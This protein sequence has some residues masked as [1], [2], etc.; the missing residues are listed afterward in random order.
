MSQSKLLKA[1]ILK[2]LAKDVSKGGSMTRAPYPN[3]KAPLT[4][5]GGKDEVGMQPFYPLAQEPDPAAT[6]MTPIVPGTLSKKDPSKRATYINSKEPLTFFGGAKKCKQAKKQAKE[7]CAEEKKDKKEKKKRAPSAYNLFIKDFFITNKPTTLAAAAAAWKSS[8][9]TAPQPA[10]EA[11]RKVE[12][13]PEAKPKKKRAKIALTTFQP[14]PPPP[15]PP[16]AKKKRGGRKPNAGKPLPKKQLQ[17]YEK[18]P[19]PKPRTKRTSAWMAHLAEFRK[20]N[21]SVKPRDVMKEAKKTYKKSGGAH[22]GGELILPVGGAVEIKPDL[23]MTDTHTMRDGTTMSGKSHTV[24][25]KK[26]KEIM[27]EKQA[28]NVPNAP[29]KLPEQSVADQKQIMVDI[30]NSYDEFNKRFQDIS[31]SNASLG[32]KK[33]Q[34]N[35]E[36]DRADKYH[37]TAVKNYAEVLSADN[38]TIEEKAYRYVLETYKIGMDSLKEGQPT[39]RVEFE[40]M[41]DQETITKLID[42][43]LAVPRTALDRAKSFFS[44]PLP[45]AEIQKFNPVIPALG[46]MATIYPYGR[47]MA[48]KAAMGGKM[49]KSPKQM[50]AKLTRDMFIRDMSRKFPKVSRKKI[51]EVF[52]KNKSD[53]KSLI[54][55]VIID[56]IEIRGGAACK[57]GE[58]ASGDRCFKKKERPEDFDRSKFFAE[59][60]KEADSKERKD[61]GFVKE[62]AAPDMKKDSGTKSSSDAANPMPAPKPQQKDERNFVEKFSAAVTP[63]EVGPI[64]GTDSSDIT[65]ARDW[66]DS[67]A[68]IFLGTAKGV[69]TIFDALGDLF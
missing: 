20:N 18:K 19:E 6:P 32:N 53:I 52:E 11:P 65:D 43:A 45:K 30:M 9:S 55:D 66:V 44:V 24:D 4:F 17:S 39:Q 60:K 67:L 42:Q 15:G 47:Q 33:S 54:T 62:N 38:K 21:K 7:V 48:E 37:A 29:E 51:I 3:A 25:S 49:K 34:Y 46:K 41:D 69:E 23:K 8:K 2:I 28:G 63:S 59:Q 5:F 40:N 22:C 16:P 36:R 13:E 14:P 26:V 56:A 57:Q 1:D 50:L 58:Y 35:N 10:K 68:G 64:F 27:D 12:A 61:D 31:N